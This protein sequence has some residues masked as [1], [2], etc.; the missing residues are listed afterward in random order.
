MN[1]T[2]ERGPGRPRVHPADAPRCWRCERPVAVA[3][4]C[5]VCRPKEQ[6]RARRNRA[7][8]TPEQKAR[9]AMLKRMKRQAKTSAGRPQKSPP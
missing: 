4:L 6:E 7:S 5:K 1:E 8:A 2:S 9:A 3:G